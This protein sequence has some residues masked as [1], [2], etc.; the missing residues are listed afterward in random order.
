MDICSGCDS[1]CFYPGC[2][3]PVLI[4][5]FHSIASPSFFFLLLTFSQF[6]FSLLSIPNT[7]THILKNDWQMW[8]ELFPSSKI[9]CNRR[10][11][12]KHTG[13]D[14]QIGVV[15][16]RVG[17]GTDGGIDFKWRKELVDGT[18]WSKMYFWC[19]WLTLLTY[20]IHRG[21]KVYWRQ[22]FNAY[23]LL[24]STLFS[25]VVNVFASLTN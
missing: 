7:F 8:T 23:V 2:F 22:T 15:R 24:W 14:A 12:G 17:W 11:A 20:R 6:P 25:I 4:F 13:L 3:I 5:A 1:N 9:S 16:L 18:E 21:H 10:M 19:C